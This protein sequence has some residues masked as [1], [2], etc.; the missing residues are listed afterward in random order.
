[1]LSLQTFLSILLQREVETIRKPNFVIFMFKP[2]VNRVS[3]ANEYD[4]MA[5]QYA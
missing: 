3:Y 5:E 1:M 2:F 4:V